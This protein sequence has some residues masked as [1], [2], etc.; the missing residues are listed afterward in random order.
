VSDTTI[1]AHAVPGLRAG[2]APELML[3]AGLSFGCALIHLQ[4]AADHLSESRLYA[5]SFLFVAVAQ[6]AWGVAMLS[7]PS[8]AA[9]WAGIV[10]SLIVVAGWCASRT[11]GLPIGPD[12]SGPEA[13]G[14]LDVLA[15][16]DELAIVAMLAI[17][18]RGAGGRAGAAVT[19]LRTSALM[20][21]LSSS[22]VLASGLHAH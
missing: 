3:A 11:L 7:R 6:G 5:V 18:I 19:V 16:L 9:I 8:R 21:A 14:V 22:L 12:S 17:A 15:T 13:A 10:G 1:R 4:A 2:H 20:L